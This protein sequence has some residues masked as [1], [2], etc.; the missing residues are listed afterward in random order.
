[1]WKAKRKSRQ[2]KNDKK[3]AECEEFKQKREAYIKLTEQ[4]KQEFIEFCEQ[5]EKER[6]ERRN[7]W[8]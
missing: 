6:E 7:R 8:I 2:R 5:Q 3:I 4:F 1:M